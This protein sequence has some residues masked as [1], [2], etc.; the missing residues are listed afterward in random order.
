M[1]MNE[2]YTCAQCV[3]WEYDDRIANR[4]GMGAGICKGSRDV[5]GCDHK[6]CLA[7]ADKHEVAGSEVEEVQND[8]DT[9]G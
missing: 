3:W 6:A 4:Y 7:F 1:K 8:A 2:A 5:K 9:E